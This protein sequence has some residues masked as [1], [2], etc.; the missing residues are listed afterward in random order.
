MKISGIFDAVLSLPDFEPEGVRKK[1]TVLI[2]PGG[3]YSWL[4]GRE[5]L[6][7][8]REFAR[9]GY[10][11]A[12]IYYDVDTDPL[13]LRPVQQAAW[14]VAEL[15][16]LFPKEPVFPAGFSAGAHCTCSLAVHW[17]DPDWNGR[18]WL[19]EL[20]RYQRE[21]EGSAELP[22]G[23]VRSRERFR[24]DRMILAYPVISSGK[25]AHN[26]S[27]DRLTGP[28]GETAGD[29]EEWERARAW[30]S[31]ENYVDPQTC[32]AFLWHTETDGTV[33]VENSVLF[34]Q[35]LRNAGVSAELHIYPKGAHGLSL[36]TSEVEN[37]AEKQFEDAH[38]AGW[39]RL[40]AEWL[41]L[42]GL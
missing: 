8:A 9:L 42:E 28:R 12:V 20:V 5:D 3:G 15:R 41:T 35:A 23:T 17:N 38:V 13:L 24:P 34:F 40:A 29:R 14:A 33:P 11:T 22:E 18:D 21:Q 31:L 10:R 4:S 26:R 19:E 30:F 25:F 36:A 27:L 2:F 16:K 32:P 37:P 1:G 6:P 7:V 39:T